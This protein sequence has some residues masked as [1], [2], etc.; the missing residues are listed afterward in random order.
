[1][2]EIRALER[3]DIP[4][5]AQLFQK[6]F[7]NPR[8]PAP[9]GLSACLHDLFF[10]YP[11]QDTDI[12]SRVFI[13]SDGALGGFIGVLPLRMT[14]AGKPVRAA[15]PTSLMVDSPERNPTVG[16][17]LVRSFLSGPQDIS[18][19][20]PANESARSL[21]KPLGGEVAVT[22]SMEWLRVFRPAGLLAALAADRLPAQ[23]LVKAGAGVVDRL[24]RKP[25]AG[26]LDPDPPTPQPKVTD[27]D[28]GEEEL[29][30]Y[31]GRDESD[32]RLR[33]DW[34]PACFRW[35]VEH[36]EG[37]DYRGTLYRRLVRNRAGETVGCYL[38][39]GR[40]GGMAWVL[41]LCARR[42]AVADVLDCLIARAHQLGCVA[43]KGR[44]QA[45]FLDALLS[46]RCILFRRHTA[47]AHSRD[48]ELMAAV[49][50]GDAITSGLAAESW[51]RHVSDRFS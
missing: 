5:V 46:R 10:R 28:A 36:A 3:N 20:E 40:P 45:R 41:Q 31:L 26:L 51:M 48:P 24:L 27:V 11:D 32:Y 30:A 42:D 18:I 47:M 2:G 21:W 15:I 8:K 12:A 1:M 22:E 14:M 49:R 25:V 6:T 37:N 16:A 13:Q 50:S 9:D 39:H 17:K 43:I 23:K 35:I 7:A 34:S 38:Y 33:P 19:S 44:T 29:L 4:A